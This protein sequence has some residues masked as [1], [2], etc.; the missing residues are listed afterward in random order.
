MRMRE[1]HTRTCRKQNN[2]AAQTVPAFNAECVHAYA[3]VYACMEGEDATYLRLVRP[4]N[5]VS[6]NETSS[7]PYRRSDLRMGFRERADPA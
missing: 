3:R 6:G 1:P 5:T 4:L 7:L 2:G